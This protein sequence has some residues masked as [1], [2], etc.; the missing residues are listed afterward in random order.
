MQGMELTKEPFCCA[1]SI[2][3]R[4]ALQDRLTIQDLYG[5]T[6]LLMHRGW[7]EYVDILRDDL[8]KNHPQIRIQD[9]DF[10]NTEIFNQCENSNTVLLAI[11]S[12]AS[13]HPLMRILPVEW[14]YRI[15]FGLLYSTE[16]SAKVR[17]LLSA[18]EQV[19]KL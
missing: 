1:V 11:Q 13:V 7:S 5:E 8:W 2:H 17:K 14:D 3:H 12:W 4:L 16:P 18:V 6:L 15:P 19:I 10:Y 9:F